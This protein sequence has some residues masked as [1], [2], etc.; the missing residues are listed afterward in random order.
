MK[1]NAKKDLEA[2]RLEALQS[3]EVL[4]TKSEQAFDDLTA[5]VADACQTPIALVSLVDTDRQ[6]FKSCHGLDAIETPREHGFCDHAVRKPGVMVVPD[7][8]QDERFADNPLVTGAPN[9][10][11]YAGSPLVDANGHALGA[12]CVIDR[13]PRQLSNRQFD[14]LE[15]VSRQVV[16][17][18]ELRRSNRNMASYLE[19]IQSLAEMIPMCG[20]CHAVRDDADNWQRLE[21]YFQDVSGTQVTHGV[22]PTCM[23]KHYEVL[24]TAAPC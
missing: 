5:L 14:T 21:Q 7:A 18:L 15:Q 17:L 8:Q 2:T 23:V 11:F 3:Y 16:H 12:L 6:W 24:D 13:E 19:R 10:R 4:D 1:A 9:I 20:H 22:C